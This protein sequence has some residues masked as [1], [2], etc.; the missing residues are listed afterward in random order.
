MT[1]CAQLGVVQCKCL[2]MCMCICDAELTWTRPI[3]L[4]PYRPARPAGCTPLGVPG[5][6]VLHPFGL[7]DKR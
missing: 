6:S 4:S 5:R 2:G 1:R 7:H 3:E